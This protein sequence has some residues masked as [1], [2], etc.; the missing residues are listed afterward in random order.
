MISIVIEGPQKSG[1]GYAIAL[2]GKH[3]KS[4]GCDVKIQSEET[5]NASKLLLENEEHLKRLLNEK[6]IITEMRTAG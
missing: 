4:L 5:H 1:K 6:I 3:L 2:I